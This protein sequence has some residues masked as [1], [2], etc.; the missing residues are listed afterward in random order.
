VLGIDALRGLDNVFF[1]TS[2][3]CE[4]APFEAILRVMGVERLLFGTDFQVSQLRGRCTSLGDSFFWMYE[5]NVDWGQDPAVGPTLVGI[6]SLLALQTA[7]HQRGVGDAAV[8][9]IFCSNARQL[10]G[11]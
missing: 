2:A 6:E 4:A 8:E 1:D 3:I 5:D 11:C 9:R 10:L 7:C